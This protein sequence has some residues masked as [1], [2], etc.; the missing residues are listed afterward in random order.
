MSRAEFPAPGEDPDQY[1][2]GL[3]EVPEH[4]NDLGDG[5][6]FSGGR[7]ADGT[8]PLFCREADDLVGFDAGDRD[9]ESEN[10]NGNK[11]ENDRTPLPHP[12]S[13][14]AVTIG[15]K[16]SPNSNMRYEWAADFE[17]TGHD[18]AILLAGISF[19]RDIP[20]NT[21]LHDISIGV[22]KVPEEELKETAP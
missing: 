8:C 12:A 21:E 13:T 15:F 1:L 18:Q 4:R 6:P 5:C 19:S 20:N 16:R 7:S 2:D 10:V 14:Y 11:G 22:V 9:N 3:E 17:A